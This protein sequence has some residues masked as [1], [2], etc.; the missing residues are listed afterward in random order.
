M[1]TGNFGDPRFFSGKRGRGMLRGS[2]GNLPGDPELRTLTFKLCSFKVFYTVCLQLAC[3]TELFAFTYTSA[4]FS[5]DYFNILMSYSIGL[6]VSFY[7]LCK[8]SKWKDFMKFWITN[9]DVF[10]YSPYSNKARA[11]LFC[12]K[13]KIVGICIMGFT[14][15]E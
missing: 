9:E 8:A 7:L 2:P 12:R 13:V 1:K 10:L 15:G 3:A 6:Y 11:I 14:I 4:A 5:F